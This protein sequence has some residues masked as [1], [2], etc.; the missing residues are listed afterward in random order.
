MERMPHRR[1]SRRRRRF[2]RRSRARDNLHFL[3]A[4]QEKFAEMFLVV[5]GLLGDTEFGSESEEEKPD[6]EGNLQPSHMRTGCTEIIKF[7]STLLQ[8]AQ[9]PKTGLFSVRRRSFHAPT[10]SKISGGV[11]LYRLTSTRFNVSMQT[12]ARESKRLRQFF[13]DR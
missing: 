11:G 8:F 12:Q 4:L 13:P 1:G 2:W 10:L 6:E 3:P 5:V 9:S 7:Q